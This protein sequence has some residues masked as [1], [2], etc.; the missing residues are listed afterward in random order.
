MPLLATARNLELNVCDGL[1]VGLM[2]LNIRLQLHL[3][4]DEGDRF[5]ETRGRSPRYDRKLVKWCYFLRMR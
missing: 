5:E 2:L 3:S 1:N 4:F